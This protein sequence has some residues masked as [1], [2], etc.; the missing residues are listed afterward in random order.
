MRLKPLNAHVYAH[1]RTHKYTSTLARALTE[2]KRGVC[3]H[4]SVCS[5][6]LQASNG[7]KTP[8]EKQQ[9]VCTHSRAQAHLSFCLF[10]HRINESPLFQWQLG[11]A[12]PVKIMLVQCNSVYRILFSFSLLPTA[13]FPQRRS[14]KQGLS[15]GC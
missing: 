1:T 6:L 5:H 9:R 8:A 15:E 14:G 12:R 3:W 13:L 10:G 11:K 4:G 7:L 2:T